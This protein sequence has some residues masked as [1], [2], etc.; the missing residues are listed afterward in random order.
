M[1]LVLDPV[2]LRRAAACALRVPV[3]G[4]VTKQPVLYPNPQLDAVGR[5][6]AQ[7]EIDKCK[8]GTRAGS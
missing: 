3:C 7:R 6:V 5:D 1:R 8:S 2:R 4:C